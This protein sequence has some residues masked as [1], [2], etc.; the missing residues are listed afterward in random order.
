MNNPMLVRAIDNERVFRLELL[1]R[2][3]IE[4]VARKS[5][6]EVTTTPVGRVDIS[7]KVTPHPIGG[8][9]F[10]IAPVVFVDKTGRR[11]RR[12][13]RARS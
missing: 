2:F 3:P 1:Q 4:Y 11:D 6:R 7:I 8:I 12:A 10:Q 5:Q 9:A 13:R